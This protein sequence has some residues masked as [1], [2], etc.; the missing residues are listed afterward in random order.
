MRQVREIHASDD[1]ALIAQMIPSALNDRALCSQGEISVRPLSQ[2]KD[3]LPSILK[4]SR[5]RVQFTRVSGQE[6]ADY[7]HLP[8]SD[9]AALLK[10]M[11]RL[12][13]QTDQPFGDEMAR[14]A[15][16]TPRKVRPL[17]QLSDSPASLPALGRRQED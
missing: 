4:E 11:I 13:D 10:E 7:A 16:S 1:M 12:R 14:I 15:G 17:V 2:T 5:R 8:V 9:L 3:K 6:N